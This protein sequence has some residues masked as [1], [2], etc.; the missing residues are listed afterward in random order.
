MTAIAAEVAAALGQAVRSERAVGGGD[1]NA[2]ARLELAD[3]RVVFVKHHPDPPAGM[4]EAE[5]HGLGWLAEARAVRVPEVLGVGATWLALEWLEPGTRAAAFAV[6]LGHALAALHESGAP[7]FGLDRDNFIAILP[8]DNTPCETWE[9]LWIERRLRPLVHRAATRGRAG[10]RWH[11]RLDKLRARWRAVAGPDEPP[12]RL[13]GD[14]WSGNVHA[15]GGEPALIDPAV[16]GGHREVDLAMLALFGGL[17]DG[18]AD[19]YHEAFPLA[20]GW[21]E[22]LPLWQLYPLLVHAVLF[23]GGYGASVDRIL[24]ALT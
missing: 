4:F 7:R 9:E 5:A 20:T 21:R 14:L 24:T 16:Y 3:G 19:A 23:G 2:A 1:I 22:R 12:A 15:A 10:A 13:H 17:S 11:D 6:R 18:I 8:Q